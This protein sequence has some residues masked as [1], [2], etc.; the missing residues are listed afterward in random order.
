MLGNFSF[1][2]WIMSRASSRRKR[3]L[4]QIGHAV[5]VG[6]FER[7]N[8]GHIRD[9]LGHIRRLAQRALDFVVI[10]VA[11]Q[12]QRIALLG[13]LHRLDVHLRHQRA[14]RVNHLQAA[15]LAALAHRRRNPV[16]GVNHALSVGHIVDL[17]NEDR[18]F[19]RQLIHDIAVMHNLA[20]HVNRRAKGLQS[21]FHDVDRAH[22][23]RAEAA[24]LQ[25]QHALRAEG[26]SAL[27]TV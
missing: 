26:T 3:R 19:F 27:T 14:G 5:G 20:A 8:L 17:M 12:H 23:A 24:R 6:N 4:R 7:L 21:D 9:H 22:H 2:A 16:R 25:Q 15:P 11:D 1:S 13:K 10:A 18:A